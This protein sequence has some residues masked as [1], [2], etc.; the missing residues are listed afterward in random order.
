M[1]GFRTVLHVHGTLP[2]RDL[3][4]PQSSKC[5]INLHFFLIHFCIPIWMVIPRN[6]QKCISIRFHFK[7]LSVHFILFYLRNF[8]I[9]W[10]I[11]F[12]VESSKGSSDKI[13]VSR[14]GKPFVSVSI[15]FSSVITTLE[16]Y[17]KASPIA[18]GLGM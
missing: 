18:L 9:E 1:E 7:N 13:I 16:A 4:G 5:F 11:E 8:S 14:Y 12:W 3:Y 15:A 6:Q 10:R 2:F 17:K